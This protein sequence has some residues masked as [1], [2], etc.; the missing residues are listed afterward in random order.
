MKKVL[1]FLFSLCISGYASVAQKTSNPNTLN[2]K[3]MFVSSSEKDL[4][5]IPDNE[6]PELAFDE[7]AKSVAGFTGCNKINGSYITE[8]DQLTFGTIVSTNKACPDME[9]EQYINHFMT[10]VGSFKI[11]DY[12]L[13]LYDKIDKRKYI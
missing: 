10:N 5:K 2:G 11:D 7:I 3:W 8:R 1:L 4:G 13:Y 9:V 12:K 6:L